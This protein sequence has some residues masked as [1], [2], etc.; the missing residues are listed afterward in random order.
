M[1]GITA[2]PGHIP[3]KGSPLRG[4]PLLSVGDSAVCVILRITR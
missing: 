1:C 4:Y 3:K 2:E